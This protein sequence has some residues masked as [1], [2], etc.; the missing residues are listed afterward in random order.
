M[1]ESTTVFQAISAVIAEMEGI[2]KNRLNKDQNYKFRGV[3]DVLKVLHPLFG[4]HGVFFAPTVLERIYEERV[5]KQGTAGHVA[6]L[7]VRYKVYGPAGDFIEVSTWGEGLDY[8]DKATNK[9]MT[10]A[11]KY[12]MFELFAVADP[13]DDG[14]HTTQDGGETTDR[15]TSNRPQRPQTRPQAPFTP[16]TDGEVSEDINVIMKAA[17]QSGDEFL[18]SLAQQYMEKGRLSEKQIGAG[19]TKAMK[20]LSAPRSMPEYDYAPEDERFA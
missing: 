9:A 10:A 17:E 4:K 7:H 20:I 8:S 16:P 19:V 6:H 5:S 2:G 3:D 12:A 1:S 14:D 13:D 15:Q 11:F 18:S